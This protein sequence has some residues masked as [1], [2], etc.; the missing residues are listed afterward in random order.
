MLGVKWNRMWNVIYQTPNSDHKFP[1]SDA[2]K[3]VT[4]ITLWT[5]TGHRPFVVA[6][7]RSSGIK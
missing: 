3:L 1:I 4:F 6:G 2:C 5:D 7:G